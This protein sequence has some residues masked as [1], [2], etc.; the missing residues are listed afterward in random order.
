MN[1]QEKKEKELWNTVAN[2]QGEERV[3]ALIELS[4]SA[5]GQGKHKESLALC[6]TA[7]DD[8]EKLGASASNATLAHIYYGIAWSLSGLDRQ[9]EAVAAMEK[10]CELYK[11]VGTTEMI[12][13]ALKSEGDFF[14][15][16]KDYQKAFEAYS[17]IYLESGPDLSETNL[18]WAYNSCGEA[19]RKLKKWDDA[20]EYFSK[21]RW[22]YK[23]LKNPPRV[24]NLDEE[25]SYCHYKLGNPQEAEFFAKKALDFGITAENE[26]HI[27]WATARLA[28]AYKG[29]ERFEEALEKFKDAK[30]RMVHMDPVNWVAVAAVLKE[31][32]EIYT[33]L[34]SEED[35][36]DMNR[37][38][39]NLLEIVDSDEEGF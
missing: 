36:E 11:S 33:I 12:V 4:Y 5:Y 39:Y 34:G 20:L 27:M 8:Y 1:E 24:A 10:S 30:S 16:Q 6:E 2:A 38:Y 19:L 25:I 14:W 18:A 22:I 31:M 21:A 13:N 35:A 26:F 15:N 7:R 23:S 32:K 28:L 17:R 29:Q 37:K 3:D 9:S